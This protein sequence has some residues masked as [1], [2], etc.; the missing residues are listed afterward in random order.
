[1]QMQ[2]HQYI[3]EEKCTFLFETRFKNYRSKGKNGFIEYNQWFDGM[4]QVSLGQPW[5]R[6]KD[7]K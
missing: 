2:I 5:L 3:N 7:N 1:M 6:L 4:F